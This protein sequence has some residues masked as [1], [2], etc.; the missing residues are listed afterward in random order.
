M[1][2]H[3]ASQNQMC[4]ESRR[5]QPGS[6]SVVQRGIRLSVAFECSECGQTFPRSFKP[7][8]PPQKSHK[9]AATVGR[10]SNRKPTSCGTSL[11]IS[12]RSLYTVE[13][14]GEAFRTK[15]NGKR[16]QQSSRGEKPDTC[17]ITAYTLISPSFIFHKGHSPYL[18]ALKAVTFIPI[19]ETLTTELLLGLLLLFTPILAHSFEI[20]DVFYHTQRTV[21]LDL[22]LLKNP[23]PTFQYHLKEAKAPHCSACEVALIGT[24]E[25]KASVA[26]AGLA[27]D[28]EKQF[29]APKIPVP[30]DKHTALVDEEKD[31]NNCAEF[32]S[33]SQA[34]IQKNEKQLEKMKNII[35]S[36][37]M[38]TDEIFPETKLDKKKMAPLAHQERTYEAGRRHNSVHTR[39]WFLLQWDNIH[40]GMIGLQKSCSWKVQG[41]GYRLLGMSLQEF[42]TF[43]KNLQKPLDI[44]LR[45][46]NLEAE[47]T[48]GQTLPQ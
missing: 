4:G 38:I 32:L 30:E 18:K 41:H 11:F 1:D 13:N 22:P 45:A 9:C 37:Q 28:C 6:V 17:A 25:R 27:D 35:P 26:K 7:S 16:P 20:G 21:K 15:E 34:R 19:N 12:M 10:P 33:G 44:D 46:L 5:K 31:V 48:V 24:K 14:G 42:R 3:E 36:D 43:Q 8:V 23:T 40:V 47:E 39:R 29:N 2:E